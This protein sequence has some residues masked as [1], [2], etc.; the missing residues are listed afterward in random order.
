MLSELFDEKQSAFKVNLADYNINTKNVLL[1]LLLF[2]A[3]N[4]SQ[5]NVMLLA[6]TRLDGGLPMMSL[7][8]LEFSLAN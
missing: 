5:L 7:M 1:L 3:I 4:K 6:G 8:F 2:Y